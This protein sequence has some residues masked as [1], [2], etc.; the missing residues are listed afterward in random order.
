[1]N[2]IG[3]IDR[4]ENGNAYIIMQ[5]GMFEI[6]VPLYLLK[7]NHYKE[8]DLIKVNINHDKA[9]CRKIS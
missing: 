4:I 7:S 9:N 2:F 6:S 3:F 1:M 5:N 8:G